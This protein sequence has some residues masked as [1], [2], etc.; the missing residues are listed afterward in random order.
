M[1]AFD[2]TYPPTTDAGWGR[3]GR[4]LAQ[5][6]TPQ[7]AASYGVDPAAAGAADDAAADYSAELA[8]AT[9]PA[10]ISRYNT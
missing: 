4:N 7:T 8:L 2:V 9:A 10:T 6:V 5:L 3:W 1:D